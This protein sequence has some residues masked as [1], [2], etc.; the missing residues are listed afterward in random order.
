MGNHPIP[1][2]RRCHESISV[3]TFHGTQDPY[4]SKTQFHLMI[5]DYEIIDKK[6]NQTQN[7]ISQSEKIMLKYVK[8]MNNLFSL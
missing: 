3:H 4:E 1:I 2:Q 6:K 5:P 8:T 7:L